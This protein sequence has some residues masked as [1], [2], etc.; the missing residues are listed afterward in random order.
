MPTHRAGRGHYVKVV[1]A[2]GR[3]GGVGR[4]MGKSGCFRG[5]DSHYDMVC[6]QMDIIVSKNEGR[7]FMFWNPGCI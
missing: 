1:A 2:G 5:V 6:K 7:L 3:C 4:L